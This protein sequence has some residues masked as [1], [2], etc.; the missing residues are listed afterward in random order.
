MN[1]GQRVIF[2]DH[3][4]LIWRWLWNC[5][6]T[7]GN[8]FGGRKELESFNS[9]RPY[10]IYPRK[11][12]FE[13]LSRKKVELFNSKVVRLTFILKIFNEREFFCTMWGTLLNLR[14]FFHY[15]VWWSRLMRRTNILG[16]FNGG[17]S[18]RR[19][20]LLMEFENRD[21]SQKLVTRVLLMWMRLIKLK[22]YSW[23][24]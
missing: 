21:L 13:T 12:Y 8:R 5:L 20:N 7:S 23:N 6:T 9:N 4:C 18:S 15:H 24:R 14:I 1:E 16:C 2:L 17:V 3:G 19:R 22:I 11:W 10:H